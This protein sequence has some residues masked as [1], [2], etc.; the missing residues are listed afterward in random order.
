MPFSTSLSQCSLAATILAS[1][2]GTYAALSPPNPNSNSKPTPPTGDTM[3][4]LH[5]TNKL[6]TRIAFAPLGFL[7]LHTVGLTCLYPNIPP[8]LLRHG[9]ENGLNPNLVTWSTA[10]SIP[11]ALLLCGIPLRL[12]S[13][14][15]LGENFTYNLAEPDHL[16]T[17]GIYRY[18]QH[19]SYT[20]VVLVAAGN[21]ALLC[22]IDGA[23][24]CWIPSS[25]YETIRSLGWALLIPAWMPV[26]GLLWIRVREEERMLQAKFGKDW[27]RWHARTGRFIPWIF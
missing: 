27:E 13:Y 9:A 21:L 7:A 6:A 12:G 3:R 8:S 24:S 4:R 20:G 26:F 16:K 11:L 17:T 18:V 1:S 25:W 15:S 19:P 23:L 10:T 5:V 14:S 2:V 22:R